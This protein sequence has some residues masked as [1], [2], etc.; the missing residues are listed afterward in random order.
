ML[1]VNGQKN[2]LRRNVGK[3][4]MNFILK[5]GPPTKTMAAL[6]LFLVF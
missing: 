5:F 2:L 6:V 1:G 3:P 4:E